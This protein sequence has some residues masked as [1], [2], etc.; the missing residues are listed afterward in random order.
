PRNIE[1]QQSFAKLPLRR[2]D[3][4][5]VTQ[6]VTDTTED[7]EKTPEKQGSEDSASEPNKINA[8]TPYDF[9]GKN[10]TPY[11][12][13][14]PVAAM[15]EKLDFPSHEIQLRRHKVHPAWNY[16]I[17]PRRHTWPSCD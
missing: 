4:K 8:S 11:G 3:S 15:L 7:N 14:L 10:L 2:T 1:V 12:G 17:S 13:L 9:H 6:M 16:T 5:E